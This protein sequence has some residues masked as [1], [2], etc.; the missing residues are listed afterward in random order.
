MI[1]AATLLCDISDYLEIIARVVVYQVFLNLVS[2][3]LHQVV[4]F[5]WRSFTEKA[6]SGIQ[7]IPDGKL[8]CFLVLVRSTNGHPVLQR[9]F[10]RICRE[11]YGE[12][13]STLASNAETIPSK[14]PIIIKQVLPKVFVKDH[15]RP[16]RIRSFQGSIRCGG[17][18][19]RSLRLDPGNL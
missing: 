8:E 16:S 1:T 4:C 12:R 10:Q 15:G 19:T 2:I 18:V 17:L 9:R 6:L 13:F 14:H 7:E 11:G 3:D 5:S